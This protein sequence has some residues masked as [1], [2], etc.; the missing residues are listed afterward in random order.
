MKA[1]AKTFLAAGDVVLDRHGAFLFR[2]SWSSI[3]GLFRGQ[4]FS[5][6]GL[7]LPLISNRLRSRSARRRSTTL[8]G[9]SYRTSNLPVGHP[10]RQPRRAAAILCVQSVRRSNWKKFKQPHEEALG[11]FPHRMPIEILVRRERAEIEQVGELQGELFGELHGL[12]F[13]GWL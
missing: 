7:W 1:I 6:G 8:G 10:R 13:A 5:G 9:S 2:C 11:D 12:G 3:T 4:S